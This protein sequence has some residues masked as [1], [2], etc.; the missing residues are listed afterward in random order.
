MLT[1]YAS[2]NSVF[3][4][5]QA[6]QVSAK[7]TAYC[8]WTDVHNFITSCWEHLGHLSSICIGHVH[9]GDSAAL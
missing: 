4:A 8:F 9:L 2:T 6:L 5:L 7:F 1:L 3:L